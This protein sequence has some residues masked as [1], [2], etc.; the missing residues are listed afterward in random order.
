MSREH[1][2]ALQSGRRD[3]QRHAVTKRLQGSKD[4]D[5]RRTARLKH[6]EQR[7]LDGVHVA[8]GERHEEIAQSI[9]HVAIV[10]LLEDSP[11]DG[12]QYAKKITKLDDNVSVRQG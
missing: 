10:R 9:A 2:H 12:N 11:Q 6:V 7:V 1:T 4:S 8:G 5:M 3:K